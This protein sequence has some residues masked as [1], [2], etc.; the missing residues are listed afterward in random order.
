MNWQEVAAIIIPI[1]SFMGWVYSRIEKKAEERER[2]S[3]ARFENLKNELKAEI[4]GVRTESKLDNHELRK[5]VGDLRK[6]IQLLDSRL[7]RMEG[8]LTGMY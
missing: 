5:E 4:H 6:D 1:I 2:K 7:A 8:H 3:K